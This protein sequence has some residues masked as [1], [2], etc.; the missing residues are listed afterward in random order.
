MIEPHEPQALRNHG[1][2]LA[3]LAG[4]GGLGASEAVAILRDVP[5]RDYWDGV[6]RDLDYTYQ[7]FAPSDHTSELARGRAAK[8]LDAMVREWEAEAASE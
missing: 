3:Q 6:L 8:D 5:W 7:G 1:Q 2:T 4:R